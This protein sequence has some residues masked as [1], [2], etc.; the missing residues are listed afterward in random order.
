MSN[1]AFVILC[2]VFSAF[3][4]SV[5]DLFSKR[6]A[7]SPN[8]RFFVGWSFWIAFSVYELVAWPWFAALRRQ[9]ELGRLAG[10]W[11][12]VCLLM[13]CIIG[14]GVFDE[15]LSNLNKLGVALGVLSVLC[16]FGEGSR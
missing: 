1:N 8:P 11:T 9:P 3:A 6:W 12:V 13:A 14:V 4:A 2:V 16:L 7:I 5:A 10:I 15:K